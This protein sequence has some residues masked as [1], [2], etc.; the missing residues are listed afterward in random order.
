MTF[1]IRQKSFSYIIL[2]VFTMFGIGFLFAKDAKE[3]WADP[4]FVEPDKQKVE[5][6]DPQAFKVLFVGNS[7]TRHGVY[8]ELGWNHE[9]G[10]AASSEAN[11]YAHITVKL[12]QKAMPKRKVE[13]YYGN[14]NLLINAKEQ[15][16]E[17]L[18]VLG[19]NLPKP[20]LIIVQT[21]EHEGPNKSNKEVATLYE[22]KIIKPLVS[23]KVPILAVGVWYP[24]DNQ[25]Y[26]AWVKNIDNTYQNI[27]KKYKIDFASVEKYARDP[28]CR[29][30]G[31]HDAVK[32]HP[33]D[34][35]MNGYATEIMNMFYKMEKK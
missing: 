23:L 35:G 6:V 12:L 18:T 31:T 21:G 3:A 7:I 13:F 30:W 34:A 24:T 5:G 14:V 10:M 4:V 25:P 16:K 2:G 8:K 28:K 1:S 32:W 22:D 27:C 15:V 29:N 9:A 11:D 20:D 17:P 26:P 33:S 19:N